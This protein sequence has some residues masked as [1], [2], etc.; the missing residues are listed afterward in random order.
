MVVMRPLILIALG[1]TPGSEIYATARSWYAAR[2]RPAPARDR[3]RPTTSR[4]RINEKRD[5]LHR[6]LR[7]RRTQ[8]EIRRRKRR[9]KK[10]SAPPLSGLTSSDASTHA[11]LLLWSGQTQL[12]SRTSV[13]HRPTGLFWMP[14]ADCDAVLSARGGS[15]R[16]VCV[17]AEAGTTYS[18]F[19]TPWSMMA[20]SS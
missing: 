13:T 11:V 16:A 6:L 20:A 5:R 15:I 2:P 7:R 8:S 18:T 19:C 4:R 9:K 17:L 12:T 10:N 1:M 14:M 3:S